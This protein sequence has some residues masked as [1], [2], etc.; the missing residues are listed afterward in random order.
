MRAIASLRAPSAG[1]VTSRTGR[2]GQACSTH[3]ASAHDGLAAA[4][5]D[6]AQK[7]RRDRTRDDACVMTVSTLSAPGRGADPFLPLMVAQR[8]RQ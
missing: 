1:R 8:R 3:E 4:V 2:L 6:N 5:S 7:T